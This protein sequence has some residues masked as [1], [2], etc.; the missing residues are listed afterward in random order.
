MGVPPVP[1]HKAPRQKDA[2]SILTSLMILSLNLCFLSEVEE[3]TEHAP[4][5]WSLGSCVS[6]PPCLCGM[7]F[8]PPPL[9]LPPRDHCCLPHCGVLGVGAGVLARGKT[10]GTCEGLY[11]SGKYPCALGVILY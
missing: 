2:I 9:L 11:L 1:L 6:P 4:G 10:S 5:A 7:G 8:W 3:T